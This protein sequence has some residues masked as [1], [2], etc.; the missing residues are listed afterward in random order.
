MLNAVADGEDRHPRGVV[1]GKIVISRSTRPISRPR[2]SSRTSTPSKK[3][4]LMDVSV[5]GVGAGLLEGAGV[6]TVVPAYGAR[7]RRPRRTTR[8]ESTGSVGGEG[9]D[10]WACSSRSASGS[11]S[12]V[13][14]CSRR[15]YVSE[16]ADD[17]QGRRLEPRQRT[18]RRSLARRLK[19]WGFRDADHDRLSA[20]RSASRLASRAGC[21]RGVARRRRVPAA[22]ALRWRSSRSPSSSS[23][24]ACACSC[25]LIVFACVW[26]VLFNV[27]YGVQ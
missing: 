3:Y 22:G 10:R 19:A 2:T 12:R 13:C 14:R 9:F 6:V 1:V 20:S 4:G 18:A 21:G 8:W 27:R 26:P 23:A 11:S 7:A 15:D 16:R 5:P 17:P 25:L 24:S